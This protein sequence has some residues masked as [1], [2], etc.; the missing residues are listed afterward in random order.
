LQRSTRDARRG[1]SPI[2]PRS[3]PFA[4]PRASLHE[5]LAPVVHFLFLFILFTVAG[6]WIL[7]TAQRTEPESDFAEPATAAAQQSLEPQTLTSPS[8][9]IESPAGTPTA[10]GPL[11]TKTPRTGLRP[12]T[13]NRSM[14]PNPQSS[15]A[16][17]PSASR[18]AQGKWRLLPQIQTAD[19]HRIEVGD[20]PAR[21]DEPAAPPAVAR[22]TGSILAAPTQQ[23]NHDDNQSSLH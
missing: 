3:D 1:T 11:G 5:T 9:A 4:I 19:R 21:S 18:L 17:E 15:V 8:K 7:T 23:A 10:A 13:G 6:T 22:L 12:R 14:I 16:P 2:L 20:D